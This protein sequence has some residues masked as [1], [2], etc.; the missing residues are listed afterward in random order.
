MT[1]KKIYCT[2]LVLLFSISTARGQGSAE[3]S[4]SPVKSEPY[5]PYVEKCVD[6]LMEYGT[7]RY[8]KIHAPILV[9][10]LDVESRA[11]PETPMK[12]DEQWRVTRRE[13]RNPA[14][15]NLLTDQPLLRTM[16]WL[17]LVTAKEKYIK[18]SHR[19]IDYYINNLI[20]EKDFFWW[21]WHRHY[22]VYKDMMDGHAGNHH[23]IHAI[24]SIDWEMLWAVDSGAVQKE[25]EAIWRWHVI[26]KKTGEINRHGDGKSGCDFSMSAGAYIEAF[27]FMYAKTNETHWL[28]RAKLLANYY[29][30]RRHPGTNL[31]PDRPNAGEERFD[32]SSFVTSITGPYCHSLLK[33][34]EL[35]NESLFKDQAI[36]YLKAY[37][38]FGFDKESGR[39]RGALNLDGTGV[40]GP[41]I[42]GRYAQYEPRGNL[43]LW[44]PYVAGYQY[45]IYTAQAYV[46]VYQLTNDEEF[47]V[48]ATRFAAWINKTPP[49]SIESENSWYKDYSAGPGRQ[50][51]YAGKYGRTISFFLHLYIVT[52]DRRYLDVACRWADTAIETLYHNGLFR[53]HPAK[54][55][56]E[57]IDG[58]GYLLYALLQLDIVLENPGEVLSKQSII[59]DNQ[60]M[61]LDNW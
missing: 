12:L 10:I 23:E 48:T 18:F 28:D 59:L 51:T 38:T 53:G 43:D 40:P 47:L 25:I 22:D 61:A 34:Y 27:V 31:F 46:Y 39:F 44:E 29:W 15:A 32:G 35:T 58:V 21:G 4:R 30:T 26:D 13:R 2:V 11:C 19:Y 20:D 56:Y 52:R 55:Y 6:L 24:N 9:S 50:G 54:P 41:R 33:A 5:T 57:A 7:D 1:K 42:F 3:M 49:G 45:A 60:R 8:G 37:A 17:S 16:R 14:G 36:A